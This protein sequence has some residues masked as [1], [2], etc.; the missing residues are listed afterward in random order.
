MYSRKSRKS[1]KKTTFEIFSV[2]EGVSVSVCGL[3]LVCLYVSTAKVVKVLDD[4]D[5]SPSKLKMLIS[6]LYS[7]CGYI[8]CRYYMYTTN[9]SVS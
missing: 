8:I 9:K 4:A 5:L 1:S 7:I 6:T 2:V 3:S